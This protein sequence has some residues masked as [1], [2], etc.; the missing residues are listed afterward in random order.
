MALLAKNG[1]GQVEPNHLSAQRTGKIY[2]QLPADA[3]TTVLENGSFVKYNQ[4]AGK[5]D[6]AGLGAWRM[7]FNEI[8]L[9]D[10]ARQ[11]TK[12]F[13]LLKANMV[14]G[15]MTPRVFTIESGDIFTTNLVNVTTTAAA[16]VGK[17]LVPTGTTEGYA[18]LTEKVTPAATDEVYLAT[19]VTTMPDGQI[20]LKVTKL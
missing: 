14:D 15:V 12:D 16:A 9:Y 20:A 5:V 8:K 13:A 4:V 1:Y 19:K 2:A 7:V 17:Y 18:V 6:E 3:A 11:S 10:K